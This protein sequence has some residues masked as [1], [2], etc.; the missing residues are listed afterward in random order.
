M[1]DSAVAPPGRSC[2]K[3]VV[4]PHHI[5]SPKPA[6]AAA[7]PSAIPVDRMCAPSVSRRTAC[8]VQAVGNTARAPSTDEV[9][10]RA[11]TRMGYWAAAACTRAR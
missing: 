4:I 7:P 1:S 5:S 6:A 2:S 11:D 10:R 9:P 3:A 8:H